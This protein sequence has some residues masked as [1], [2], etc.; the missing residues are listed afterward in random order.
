MTNLKNYAPELCGILIL[1]EITCIYMMILSNGSDKNCKL[2]FMF[3]LT[4]WLLNSV[5]LNPFQ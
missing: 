5:V 4:F 3:P 1:E 2:Y